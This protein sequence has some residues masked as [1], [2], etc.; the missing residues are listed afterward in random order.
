MTDDFTR[1]SASLWAEPAPPLRRDTRVHAGASLPSATPVARAATRGPVVPRGRLIA[2]FAAIAVIAVASTTATVLASDSPAVTASGVAAVG[3]PLTPGV[4]SLA[5][6]GGG[7]AAAPDLRTGSDD[8]GSDTDAV[9]DEPGESTAPLEHGDDTGAS[10]EG[11]TDDGIASPDDS[12]VPAPTAPAPGPSVP[13]G[14]EPAP[15]PSA[16]GPEPAPSQPAP[17]QPAPAPTQPAPAPSQPAPAP[18]VAAPDP[19][20]FVGISKNQV[21]GLLGIRVLSSYTLSLSGEPG[22][23]ASVQ[24]GSLRAGSVTFNDNG[25]ASITLGRSL[26]DVGLANPLITVAYSDGTP[27]DPISARRDSI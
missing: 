27:G 13:G 8:A 17:S 15:Q 4:A 6:E 22:A 11:G 5:A 26:L 21:I 16:P 3:A 1:A 24:Y 25:R 14:S 23:T 9:A 18:P 20:G 10:A 12:G 7:S 19:L 2:G